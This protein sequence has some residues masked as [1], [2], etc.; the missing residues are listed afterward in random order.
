LNVHVLTQRD[1]FQKYAK[2]KQ[3]TSTFERVAIF[4]DC[5]EFS[6]C[7]LPRGGR[8]QLYRLNWRIILVTVSYWSARYSSLFLAYFA[9]WIDRSHSRGSCV[10]SIGRWLHWI[11]I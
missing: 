5:N 6:G 10:V 8:Q 9:P 3:S 4:G 7:N 11:W 2:N 1:L